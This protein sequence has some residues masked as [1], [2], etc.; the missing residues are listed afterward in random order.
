MDYAGESLG[1]GSFARPPPAHLRFFLSGEKGFEPLTFGFGN[2]CS[3]IG[4]ILLCPFRLEVRTSLFHGDNTGSIP[5]RGRYCTNGYLGNL[6]CRGE[7]RPRV[8]L[9]ALDLVQK[10]RREGRNPG[11]SLCI[12]SSP[13]PF[14][15]RAEF[16]FQFLHLDKRKFYL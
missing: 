8:A 5:V 3:T 7:L 9:P 10:L 11:A 6:L 13:L 15:C 2:H 12:V 16:L 14:A 1:R 4:T